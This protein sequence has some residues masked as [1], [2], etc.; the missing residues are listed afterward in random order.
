MVID[1][2]YLMTKP[3]N[4]LPSM[5]VPLLGCVELAPEGEDSIFEHCGQPVKNLVFSETDTKS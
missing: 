5:A 1:D 2:A 3:A 4:I